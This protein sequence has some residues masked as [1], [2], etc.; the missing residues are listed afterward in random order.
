MSSSG[1]PKEIRDASLSSGP[2]KNGLGQSSWPSTSH[3]HPDRKQAAIHLLLL[4]VSIILWSSN[5]WRRRMPPPIHSLPPP[6]NNNTT[7]PITTTENTNK[8]DPCPPAALGDMFRFTNDLVAVLMVVGSLGA[9]VHSCSLQ[10]LL[11]FFADLDLMRE[12]VVVSS[13]QTYYRKAMRE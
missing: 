11:H 7:M 13:R 9:L 3:P 12:S 4:L 1:D 10:L 8:K 2:T 5:V 6:Q